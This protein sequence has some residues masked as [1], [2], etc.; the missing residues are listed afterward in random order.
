MNHDKG[1]ILFVA[2]GTLVPSVYSQ[3]RNV[4]VVEASTTAP[5][6]ERGRSTPSSG[7]FG[8]PNRQATAP[9]EMLYQLELLQQEVQQLRPGCAKAL[10]HRLR[11]AHPSHRDQDQQQ[12]Q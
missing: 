9:A 4:P 5:V 12:R 8:A 3:G 11:A 6:V 1:L 7:D 10:H 2:L